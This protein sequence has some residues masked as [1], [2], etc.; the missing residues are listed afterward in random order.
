MGYT[1]YYYTKK[2]LATP[3]KWKEFCKDVKKII[4]YSQNE[5][6]I[7]LA[8]G[9]SKM[10][11]S[12]QIKPNEICFNGSDEQPIGIWTTSTK[13]SIPWPAPTAFANEPNPDPV[14]EKTEGNWFAGDLLKQRV[15]PINDETNLGSGSYETFCLN[16]VIKDKDKIK[17]DEMYFDCCKTAF[18]PYDLV[19][20]AILVAAKHHFGDNIR[21]KSDGKNPEWIDGKILCNNLLG[22][23]LEYEFIQE[24]EDDL[25]KNNKL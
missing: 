9:V 16:R 25:L 19:I 1:H 8:D 6:G 2:E 15:A 22:Y 13:I 10:G 21:I 5:L 11:S 3:T 17:S 12:P 4:D 18:R 20:T 24:G 7:K 23:G 14:A